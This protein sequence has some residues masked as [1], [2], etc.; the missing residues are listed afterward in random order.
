MNCLPSNI[1]SKI[2]SFLDFEDR[3]SCIEASKF[4]ANISDS[5]EFHYIKINQENYNNKLLNFNKHILYLLK[6]KPILKTFKF[7]FENIINFDFNI[8]LK[9]PENIEIF[10]T[11][12]C[13]E[14]YNILNIFEKCNYLKINNYENIKIQVPEIIPQEFQLELV[15]ETLDSLLDVELIKKVTVLNIKLSK[16]IVK[17]I[18]LTNVN[19]KHINLTIPNL[20][21]TVIQPHKISSLVIYDTTGITSHSTLYDSFY[22]KMDDSYLKSICIYYFYPLEGCVENHEYYKLFKLL[23]K[24]TNIFIKVVG[25]PVIVT[26]LRTCYEI[27][28][29]IYLWCNCEH[30]YREVCLI[31]LL[32]NNKY[33]ISDTSEIKNTKIYNNIHE[34][35]NEMNNGY[36]RTYYWIKYI[37]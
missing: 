25:N 29:N 33:K 20:S 32:E 3:K 16:N 12:D 21:Y 4:F 5:Y 17:R 14:I 10:I 9:I 24:D 8:K 2:G 18:D 34:I 35:Y 36:K 23:P 7:E 1:I 27:N 26:F 11:L 37:V 15:D 22:N 30:S 28:K 31:N 6:I 19:A 13:Q